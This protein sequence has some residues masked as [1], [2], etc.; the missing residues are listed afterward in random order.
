M[1]LYNALIIMFTLTVVLVFKRRIFSLTIVSLLW[2]TCG[3]INCVVL[4]FRITP[5]SAVD[6]EI[7]VLSKRL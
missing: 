6:L 2:L 1:F 4:G 7:L 3:I 5:F